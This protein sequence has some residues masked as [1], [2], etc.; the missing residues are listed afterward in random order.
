MKCPACG[1]EAVETGVYCHKC[2]ARLGESAPVTAADDPPPSSAKDATA[3]GPL[4]SAGEQLREAV[5]PRRAASAE[6]ERELWVGTYSHRD[7]WSVW[8]I[9]GAIT[10]VLLVIGVVWVSAAWLRWVLVLAVVALWLYGLG[11]LLYRRMSAR[12]RL[13]TK[14]FLHEKGILRRVTDRIEVIDM[15]D[16][17]VEQTIIDRMT[18]VG[19]IKITSSDRTHPVLVLRGIENVQQVAGIMDETRLEER[20]RRGLHIESI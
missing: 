4:P 16:I 10:A 9:D 8:A 5:G 14:R 7:M 12:Y 3:A 17:T 15:D 6:S 1:T 19:T 11:T 2:G 20:R 18:G 13:T